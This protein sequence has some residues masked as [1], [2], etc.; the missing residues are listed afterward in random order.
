MRSFKWPNDDD[1]ENV[2]SIYDRYIQYV[3][4]NYRIDSIYSGVYKMKN[5]NIED[6]I[7][8]AIFNDILIHGLPIRGF[9]K[10]DWAFSLEQLKHIYEEAFWS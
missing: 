7:Y 3:S 1:S 10:V 5:L 2:G 4:M 6:K 8:E 9:K